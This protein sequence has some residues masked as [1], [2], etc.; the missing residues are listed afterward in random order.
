MA[1]PEEGDLGS[2]SLLR[3]VREGVLCG[4]LRGRTM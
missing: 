1:D 3:F 4:G 2:G